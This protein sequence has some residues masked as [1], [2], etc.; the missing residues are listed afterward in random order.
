MAE[1]TRSALQTVDTNQNVLFDNAPYP[2]EK[3]WIIHR[4]DSG[5]F[6]LRGMTDKCLA[7]Y[8][9]AYSANIAVPTGG[10]AGPITLAIALENEGLQDGRAIYTP[11]ELD[12]FGNVSGIA[13]IKVP[14]CCCAHI[15]IINAS[16]PG[17]A[18]DVQNATIEI[19][20]AA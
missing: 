9:V 20:R 3:G 18:I 7:V 19:T 10:T 6:T 16:V 1:Y 13:I 17:Q 14:K 5:V 4:N 2:C 15:S 8:R 11:T 12:A